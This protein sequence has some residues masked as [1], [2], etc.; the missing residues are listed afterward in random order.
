MYMTHDGLSIELLQTIIVQCK[1]NH[2]TF[3]V[4]LLGMEKLF[5]E[6]KCEPKITLIVLNKHLITKASNCPNL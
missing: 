4:W 6:F 3:F 5:E 2:Q 1:Q